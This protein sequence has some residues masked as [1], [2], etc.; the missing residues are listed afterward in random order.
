MMRAWALV[1][2]TR[3][4]SRR[5]S[6]RA[7]GAGGT[8]DG[9]P[10]AGASLP[11][12]TRPGGGAAGGVRPGNS[13]WAAGSG[14]ADPAGAAGIARWGG[15]RAGAGGHRL[16]GRP[17]AALDRSVFIRD[18]APRSGLTPGGVTMAVAAAAQRAGLGTIHA[19]RLRH[20]AATAMLAEAGSLAEIGQVLR[21]RRAVTTAAYVKVNIE[22]LRTLARPWPGTSS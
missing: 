18:R 3:P 17:A 8:Q 15:R 16:A 21:H 19:H 4:R 13:G 12:G 14:D 6:R 7:I 2:W 10:P 20:A 1:I 5:I 11:G 22:A 9:G